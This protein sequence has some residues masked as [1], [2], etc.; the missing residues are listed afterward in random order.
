M[1]AVFMVWVTRRRVIP[2]TEIDNKTGKC[3]GEMME[4]SNGRGDS[5]CP[6]S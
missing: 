1:T 3:E 4:V 2:F 5:M 6:F